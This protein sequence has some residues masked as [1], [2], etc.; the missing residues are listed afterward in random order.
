MTRLCI[1]S[2]MIYLDLATVKVS[3]HSPLYSQPQ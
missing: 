3:N 2:Q 1:N